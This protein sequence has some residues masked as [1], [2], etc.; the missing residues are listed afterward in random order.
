MTGLRLP[1]RVRPSAVATTG[2]TARVLALL[3]SLFVVTCV[4]RTGHTEGFALYTVATSIVALLPFSDLGLGLALVTQLPKVADDPAAARRV[5]STS[6]M[7]LLVLTA[8]VVTAVL[9]I[10]PLISW[11]SVLGVGTASSAARAAVIVVVGVLVGG[12]ATVGRRVLFSLG[13]VRWAYTIDCCTALVSLCSAAVGLVLRLPVDYFIATT[14]WSP[15][16][17]SAVAS[18]GLF[19]FRWTHLRPSWRFVSKDVLRN[20]LGLGATFVYAGMAFVI[21]MQSDLLVLS[22]LLNDRAVSSYG[23]AM[24]FGVIFTSLTSV[25]IGP[26]WPEFARLIHARQVPVIRQV[27]RSTT[28]RVAVA[29]VG[30]IAF[31]MLLGPPLL[32]IWSGDPR[33]AGALL[34]GAVALNVGVQAVQSPVL[35]FVNARGHKAVIASTATVMC[36]VNLALSIALTIWVGVEGPALGT[37]IAIVLGLFLPLA[38]YTRRELRRLELKAGSPD[39]VVAT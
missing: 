23:L 16:L 35:M 5:I 19:C 17:T 1:E 10:T 2:I 30:F 26:L 22:H 13:R 39:P 28:R 33:A 14:V 32:R 20:Q 31:A 3:T 36:V 29:S 38:L 18:V 37:T 12:P 6:F 7:T 11:Q 24:R 9:L 27:L 8:G 25:V 21:S 4:Y 15:V 34:C